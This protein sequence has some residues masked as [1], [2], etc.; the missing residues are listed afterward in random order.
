MTMDTPTTSNLRRIV[1]A[2]V[3]AAGLVA[4]APGRGRALHRDTGIGGGA[5]FGEPGTL[6]VLDLNADQKE[7]IRLAWQMHW[8][9][10]RQL[11]AS[12]KAAR[13][14]ID[15]RLLARGDVTRQEL[16]GLAE[17]E[18]QAHG[19]LTR[20]RLATALDVRNALTPDQIQQV[21]A[22]RGSVDQ[23]RARMHELDLKP[24]APR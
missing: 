20:E 2:G 16:E 11:A 22:I 6:H 4:S 19:A 7:A 10:L 3:L 5:F 8:A 23:A 13:H 14:A 9:T 21:A 24:L 17:Q 18:I 12:D 15:D 1:L